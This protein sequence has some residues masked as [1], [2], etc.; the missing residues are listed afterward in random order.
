MIS[1]PSIAPACYILTIGDELL[2]GQ[3]INTNSAWIS[4]QLT[5][6]GLRVCEHRVVADSKAAIVSALDSFVANGSIVV[7][8]GGLGPTHDDITKAVLSEYFHDEL[9]LHQPTL[10]YLQRYF[11]SRGRVFSERNISQALQPSRA[12]ILPNN[13]G[14]APGIV[15]KMEDCIVASFPGV[16]SEMRYLVSE[17]FLPFLQREVV[18]SLSRKTVYRSIQT[19]G[20][21]EADLADVIG[22]ADHLLDG[23]SL[24]FLPSTSGVKLRIGGEINADSETSDRD[25]IHRVI[26]EILQRSEKFVVSEHG[27]PLT[28]SVAELLRKN[29]ST[30]AVAESCTSGLLAAELTS[31]AGSSVYFLGGF[32]CYSNESKLEQ[33]G[34]D[35]GALETFG[36]VSEAVAIELA[37]K[38]R[39]KFRSTYALS[40]TGIAGPDGGSHLKPVGT[41][42]VGI[43][44][45]SEAFAKKFV[46]GNHRAMNRERAV[47]SALHLLFN[48]LKSA[49]QHQ[50]SNSKF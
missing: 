19:S 15:F 47:T 16:P 27:V 44:T 2:I 45:P 36:A 33:V 38:T 17:H 43:A 32:L 14:T 46:F 8:T 22:V 48:E 34:I 41:T 5:L 37:R 40:I 18:D 21:A 12:M 35:A 28:E 49:T 31:L 39:V 23:C 20:I 11:Q 26:S 6:L 3:T 50:G 24:A 13:V 10:Q 30:V 9:T 1:K 4:E 7:I 42:W 29:H 25:K